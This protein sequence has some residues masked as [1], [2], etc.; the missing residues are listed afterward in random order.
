MPSV[1]H[2]Y[3]SFRGD[4]IDAIPVDRS[5]EFNQ[6]QLEAIQLVH[7]VYSDF[8]AIQLSA[9]TH[10]LGTP[11]D[12]TRKQYG[13]GAVIPDELILGHFKEL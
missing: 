5:S 11:W 12:I 2:T 3:K 1:Y 4:P 6:K 7:D 10:R 8:S 9:L 13:L